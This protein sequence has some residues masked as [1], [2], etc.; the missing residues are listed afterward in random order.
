MALA[1][2]VAVAVV[3]VAVVMV[4]H[5]PEVGSW[6]FGMFGQTMIHGNMLQL[7]LPVGQTMKLEVWQCS[8]RQRCSAA[9]ARRYRLCILMT[10]LTSHPARRYRLCILTHCG[11]VPGAG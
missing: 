2:A 8:P 10:L 1:V 5:P 7:S 3:A 9:A 11:E 4:A 6:R